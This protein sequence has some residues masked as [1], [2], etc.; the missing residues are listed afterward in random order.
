MAVTMRNAS[1]HGLLREWVQDAGAAL[2][3]EAEAGAEIPFEVREEPGG[4]TPLY[5]YRP[6]TGSFIA[7]RRELVLTLPAAAPARQALERLDGLERYLHLRGAADPGDAAGRAAAAL[8]LLLTRT[9][10]EAG[11]FAFAPRRFAAA[12]AELEDAVY[13]DRSVAMVLAPV[14]GLELESDEVPLAGGLRLVRTAAF[15][16]A[17]SEAVRHGAPVLAVLEREQTP[18]GP[19][20]V[21]PARTALRRLLSALRLWDDGSFALGPVAW[22]RV[23]GGPWRLVALGGSGRTGERIVLRPAQEDELRAFCSLVSRRA[24]R[25]GELA[26]ALARYEM[27]CE[28]LS[29]LEALTDHLLAL[30][31]LLEPEGPASARLPQRLAALCAQPLDRPALAER[32]ADA[33]ALERAVVAGLAGPEAPAD[34][35]ASELAGHLR[36]LLRDTVCGHLDADLRALADELLAEAVRREP[37]PAAQPGVMAGWSVSAAG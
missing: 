1:L 4:R 11:D 16:E 34:A 36:A 30:R 17:P 12:H 22:A 10:E 37:A 25:S 33:A 13:A 2:A 24:P 6:L 21:G 29:P 23:N 32:A 26:W 20:V 5:C 14:L 15:D 31:A 8:R 18:G 27:G 7:D 3:A 28:R 35:L 19:G 9:Y